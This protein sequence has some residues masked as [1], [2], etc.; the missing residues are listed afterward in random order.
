MSWTGLKKAI[1]R[2]GNHVLL[3]AGQI[4][5]TVDIEFDYEE[6]RFRAMEKASTKLHKDLRRYKETL[7]SLA[8]AQQNVS[9]VLAGF[10]GSEAKCVAKEYQQATKAIR[11]ETLQELGEPFFQT[12]LN[13]IDR[14]NSYYVDMNEAIKKRAHKKLDYDS[15]RS[16]VRKLSENPEKDPAREIKLKDTRVQLSSAEEVYNRLNAQ[17]KGDLPRLMDLRISYLNPSFEAFVKLQLRYFSE[18][19][20]H[21]NEAKKKLDARTRADYKNGK[22][23]KRLDEILSKVKEL[24]VAN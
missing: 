15:L 10:Y 9:D 22:M 7:T 13:P 6:K 4:D 21:L 23:E 1:N 5:E 2:A 8:A 24:N 18:N 14:F 19:H 11:N 12:V 16:K 17:L 3:K 20:R